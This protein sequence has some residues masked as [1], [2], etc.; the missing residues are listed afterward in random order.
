MIKETAGSWVSENPAD[1]FWQLVRL[2]IEESW[3]RYGMKLYAN[4]EDTHGRYTAYLRTANWQGGFSFTVEALTRTQAPPIVFLEA[5][6]FPLLREFARAY[7]G[8]TAFSMTGPA[9]LTPPTP[10]TR[11]SPYVTTCKWI[12][13][14][15]AEH[16]KTECGNTMFASKR[17]RTWI[18]RNDLAHFDYCPFCS[19]KIRE[20]E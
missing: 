7:S 10:P 4:V 15:Q 16:Y 17:I 18:G 3:G 13:S 6:V 12:Y 20:T 11:P 9:P 1:R 5:E 2:A 19:N 14:G 8:A